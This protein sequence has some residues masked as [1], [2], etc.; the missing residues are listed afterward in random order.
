MSKIDPTIRYMHK[1]QT[2]NEFETAYYGEEYHTPWVSAVVETRK[3]AYNKLEITAITL[4]NLV[5][6]VDVPATGGTADKNNCVYTVLGHTSD[7]RSSVITRLATVTGSAS[8]EPTLLPN[9]HSAGTLTLTATYNGLSASDSVTIYQEAVE[10]FVTGI[11]LDN[12]VWVTNM[13]ATGGTAT[14]DNCTYS[15]TAHYN[16][17]TSADVTSLAT[18]TGSTVVPETEEIGLH[19]AGTLTLTASYSGFNA[20]DSVT[21]YQ[22]GV[23]PYEERY[24]TLSVVSAGTIL[25]KC[26]T[27]ETVVKT[28]EYSMDNGQT[29]SS[30]TATSAGTA[31]NV[32]AGDKVMFRGNNNQYAVGKDRNSGFND[33][34][35]KYNIEGNVMSLVYGDNFI[36]QTALTKT[37]TFHSLF[38]RSGAISAEHFI[39]PATA[40]TADCY[41][42]MFANAASLVVPPQLP[43]TTLA[44][45]CYWY[46]FEN[47]AITEAPVLNASTL[48]NGCYG[49]MF[50]GCT[51]LSYIKCLATD[52][53]ASACT[54]SWVR[55]V[56]PSGIFVKDPSMNDWTVGDISGIPVG[57]TPISSIAISPSIVSIPANGG[58]KEITVMSPDNWSAITAS[59]WVT[60]TP[61][62]GLQGS[63]TVSISA[64]KTEGSRTA[65]IT[66]TDGTDS[67]TLTATQVSYVAQYLTLDV[68]SA[69]T[70]M[71]KSFGTGAKTISYSLDN[72]NTWSAI[73]ATAQGVPITVSAG[74]RVLLKGTESRYCNGDKT[75]YSGFDDSNTSGSSTAG[76]ARYN[77]EGNIMSLLYGDNFS[78][79]TVLPSAWTFTQLFKYSNAVSAKNLI[80]PATEL[81]ECCYRAMFSWATKL[82]EAPELPALTLAKDCYWYMFEKVAITSIVLPATTLVQGCYGN[83]F[84]SA[85]SVNHIECMATDISASACTIGWVKAVSGSGTFVKDATMTSWPINSV[86]GIPVGWTVEDAGS[87]ADPVI[88]CDGEEV[89]IT[90]ATSGAEIYYNVN[91][92]RS[93]TLYTEPFAISGNV[94]VQ[95]YATLSGFTSSTVTENCEY[96]P[97]T[98]YEKSNKVLSSWTYNNQ[99]I[100]VPYSVNRIDG[101]S[102]SYA[103]GT[104]NFE[105]SVYLKAAQPT[106]LWFQHADQSATI[107]VD[108]VEVEKH[109]GGYAAF[110]VDISN[111]VHKGTNNIKVALKNNE[112]NNLA[113]ASGDFNINA[114]LGKVKLFTSPVLPAMSY[115]YDGFHITAD[116]A[117]SSAT[118]TV[119]TAIPTG[120]TVTCE[121]DDGTFHYGTSADS[122]GNEMIF[123]ATVQNPHLWNG[124]S[125]PHLYDVTLNIYKDG[126]LYHSYTRPY[127]LRFYEYVIDQV[128]GAGTYTG[129][130]LNGQPYLLRGCCMHDDIEGKANALN[131]TDYT[132]TFSIV[133]ELGLNFLRLAHYPHPKEVYDWCD[134]LGIVVQ[135][136][137]PCV[138]H[139]QMTMPESYWT[140]LTGQYDDMVNQ[141]YNHPCIFFWGLSNEAKV[142]DSDEGREFAKTKI[143][144]Y[145][146]QIKAL[147]SERMVG[148]VCH[149]QTNP[150]AYFG[151]PTNIDW[152]GNNLYVGWYSNQSSNNPTSLINT[153][154]NNTVRTAGKAYALSEYGCGGTQRCHSESAS[155]TTNKSSGGARHDIEYMMW[156]HE[157]HISAIKNKPEIMFT[158]QWQLFDIAVASRN[159]GYT[160]CLDGVNTSIDDELRY[161][162]D[163]GLVERDHRTKKDTF[164]LYKAWWNQ[165]DKFVHI[166]GKDFLKIEDRVIKC[167]TN[168]G[169]SLSMY[170]NDTLVETTTV[171]NSIATFSARTFENRDVVLVSGNTSN[172]SFTISGQTHDYSQDYLTFYLAAQLIG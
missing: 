152:I 35:A 108:N 3:P 164:Y 67:Q 40:L 18:V 12:L 23:T 142:T 125:D 93:Y 41:R 78:G 86:N 21:I 43:A 135:T 4:T 161:L 119:K 22:S 153:S 65:S 28:I 81:K 155:S 88:H 154:I 92:T 25:W 139:L 145:V 163:K 134:R 45:E 143:E 136:E 94:T 39:L 113:P 47:C 57:W 107:Y 168:D 131:D 158:S 104:F 61:S 54:T 87:V 84:I 24:L 122:T 55:S 58:V 123:S 74:D 60:I 83:M 76:T 103:K 98:P 132:Q 82:I 30:I 149:S 14:K 5:W 56:A 118:I 141:H 53:S 165:A 37:W 171:T 73:T 140:H 77:I 26:D 99:A 27:G 147:D 109:W 156:L 46:M 66:F 59:D 13:P 10:L 127:G 146:S 49:G 52:I 102:S 70:I 31:I 120:A 8:V 100:E 89:E 126:E 112:G 63:T 50:T 121:I 111:Y 130:L 105:T 69:G 7:G 137:G 157:G 51:N 71:W 32:S 15:V 148:L 162:N 129:F 144:G 20:S 90:C 138:N 80:L 2:T 101:H 33:G 95:A 85:T 97:E 68:I 160:V 124:L 11:T 79:Q 170:V 16:D 96:N 72:G 106:Y 36:G 48:M 62:N 117:S 150:I 75:N 169:N 151:G 114:T 167:Y 128:S 166:C 44:K 1:F 91:Q 34:T 64:L 115:G 19:S 133:Q 29:W 17:S 6:V 159:E 42:A 110:F 116:V 9:R 172:D 38:N